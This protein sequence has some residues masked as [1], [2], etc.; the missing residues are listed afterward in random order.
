[1]EDLPEEQVTGMGAACRLQ[2]RK[3]EGLASDGQVPGTEENQRGLVHRP[4]IRFE[5]AG[6]VAGARPV[7][8]GNQDHQGTWRVRHVGL[9]LLRAWAAVVVRRP[10]SDHLPRYEYEL[11]EA[12]HELR[13]VLQALRAWG[14]KW[15][16][17]RRGE[18]VSTDN[19]QLRVLAP[20]GPARA[21][22]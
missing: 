10:Y 16:S 21:P 15:R 3:G 18:E 9:S 19:L 12:G 4:H 5:L 13:A 1:V 20:A 2:Q 8:A 11:T 6:L 7:Q 17:T 22:A 14:D